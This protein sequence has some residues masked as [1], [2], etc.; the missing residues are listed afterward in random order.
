MLPELNLQAALIFRIVH[1]DNVPWILDH[2][3]H[4]RNSPSVDPNF[5]QIG[6]P[7][8]IDKRHTR[9]VKGP[10]GGTLSDYVP[11]YFTPLSPMFYNIHT[12]WNGIKQ[13]SNEEIVIFYSS[14]HRLLASNVPFIFTDRHAYL[15]AAQPFSD[16]AHLNEINWD[17]LQRR[18]FK[19]DA[20]NLEKVE[21]YEA[22]TLVHKHLPIAGL[23]GIACYN[24]SSA[25][26]I[27]RHVTAR[28]LVTEIV[29]KPNWYF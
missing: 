5:V 4:C 22:E 1:R 19:R 17:I 21:R 24:A 10:H 3:L 23:S 11:F 9:P 2:G 6:N 16:L 18:D 8:L 14:L 13:R 7:D 26:N 29:I 12:G 27:Q 25:A 20:D 28:K 15:E